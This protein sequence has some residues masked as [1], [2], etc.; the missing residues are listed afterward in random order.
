MQDPVAEDDCLLGW[1]AAGLIAVYPST[2]LTSPV[3]SF[4]QLCV[5][6]SGL[7]LGAWCLVFGV[8]VLGLPNPCAAKHYS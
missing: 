8:L 6:G 2:P 7:V 3:P 1:L 4:A 5:Q